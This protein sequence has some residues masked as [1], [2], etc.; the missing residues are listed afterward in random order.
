MNHD[1][2]QSHHDTPQSHDHHAHLP[3][4]EHTS[5]ASQSTQP[6]AHKHDTHAGHGVMHEGHATLMRDRFWICLV[7]TIPVLST[8]PCFRYGLAS[9]RHNSPAA[10]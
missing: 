6:D 4:H 9:P 1:M 2:H 8:H 5:H 10:N 3:A 7:L